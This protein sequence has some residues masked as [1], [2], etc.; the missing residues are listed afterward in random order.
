MGSFLVG[1]QPSLSALF[2]CDFKRQ[3]CKPLKT[4]SYLPVPFV[5]S[6]EGGY[7]GVNAFSGWQAVLKNLYKQKPCPSYQGEYINLEELN[8]LKDKAQKLLKS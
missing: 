6:I 2:S 5:C 3:K 8:L 4:H 7:V 1:D